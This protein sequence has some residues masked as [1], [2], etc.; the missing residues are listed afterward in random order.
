MTKLK[1]CGLREVSHALVAADAGA[2]FLGFNFVPGV[3]RQLSTEKARGIIHEYRRLRESN[4]PKLVGLFANQ[5]L[6]DVNRIVGHCWL[7]L[8]QL[9]GNEPPEYWDQITVPVI[10]QI[11]VQDDGPKDETVAEVLN[12]VGEVVR[13]RHIAMLDK[14]EAG[15]LGGTGRSFDW[16]IA[17]QVSRHQDFLMAGGLSPDNVGEATAIV[18]PWGV[19]VSSGVETDGIKD[20]E[21]IVAFAEQVHLADER[22]SG[23]PATDSHPAE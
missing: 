21:K 6:E 4:G 11:K 17:R 10:R 2:D 23:P 15:S 16:G 3:R 9:C 22:I 12:R 18:K 5:P 20:P 1:I 8:A 7:D 19:D 14:H 13:R